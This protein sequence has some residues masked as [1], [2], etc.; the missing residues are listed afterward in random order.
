M[1][2]VNDS[3]SC[4]SSQALSPPVDVLSHIVDVH[5]HPTDSAYSSEVMDNLAVQVCA[6][7]TRAT[8]QSLVRDLAAAYPQKVIPCFGYHP[9]FTH[10]ISVAPFTSKEEHYR[11]LF[12]STSSPKQEVVDAFQRLLPFLPDPTS[13]NNV[14][15]DIRSNLLQFP[16]A[17]LGEVGLDRICRVPYSTPAPTPY[18]LH[19]GKRE[20][21]PFTISLEHQLTILEAQLDLAV[22]MRRNTSLHSVKSQEATVKLLN[23]MLR[24]HGNRWTEISV[25]LHS[26][27]LSAQTLKDIQKAHPNVF[28]SLSTAI[29]TRS[30]AH[31]DLIAACPDNRIL[32]ESDYNDVSYSTRQC[33]D[34]ISRIAEVKGWAVEDQWTEDV[35]DDKW[36]V[37]RRL[38]HNWNLFRSG[39]HAAPLSRKKRRDRRQQSV[40]SSGQDS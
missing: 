24:K 28:V 16:N 19:D 5:C 39:G 32:V 7:A 35:P 20:L 40:D 2:P 3:S 9:W 1:C 27:T 33:W 23:K 22:E 4:T 6:M 31:K 38:E 12:L 15:D 14:L 21:S 8:D 13:L 26:C 18:A 29:N 37:V 10:W 34:M 17:M 11:S 25:D 30:S 36:G